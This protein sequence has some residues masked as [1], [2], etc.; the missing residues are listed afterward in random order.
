MNIHNG[1]ADD[2]ALILS[3]GAISYGELEAYI[4]MCIVNFQ[5]AGIAPGMRVALYQPTS[6]RYVISLLALI[7]MGAVACPISTRLPES[8]MHEALDQ[9]NAQAIFYADRGIARDNSGVST[10][11][12]D[13]MQTD[14]DEDEFDDDADPV[15]EGLSPDRH[16]TIIFTSG[17][18][19]TPKAA[20]HSLVNHLESA[21]ASNANIALEPGDRWLLSLP[22]FHVGGLGVV[23]RCLQAGAAVVLP[24]ADSSL[25]DTLD[26]QSVSHISLVSTQLYRLLRDDG[27]T[28]KLSSMKA[29]LMGGSAMPTGVVNSAFEAGIPIHTSFGM[30]EMATQIT[31]TPPGATP[32]QLRTSGQSLIKDNCRINSEG[33]I[34]VKGPTRFLGYFQNGALNLPLDQEG[35]F[36]T[37]DCGTFDDEGNLHVTGRVDN[38]FISG[39][40][41]IQPEEIEDYLCQIE[42]ILQAVVVPV[43]DDE[44]G[45]R[46][47]AFIRSENEWSE[48]E[49]KVTLRQS[50]PGYKIPKNILPW[51]ETEMLDGMK[52]DR[53]ELAV[54]YANSIQ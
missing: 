48:D 26:S 1:K 34:Q 2:P 49:L 19:G 40:E 42:G 28:R 6:S 52:V 36:S 51:P 14:F 8:G 18:S 50:L 24:D 33:E 13:A 4:A 29:V 30:T 53:K 7:R 35:W 43:E 46:P 9:I 47:V 37:G 5:L 25:E 16:A 23:F 41:N 22:L 31:T 17:S 3:D 32:E 54:Y 10:I 12:F 39:G 15:P 21:K 44:F 11:Y 20:V 45:H 38:Q 27:A